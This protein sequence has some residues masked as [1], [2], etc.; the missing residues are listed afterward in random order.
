MLNYR[1][2]DLYQVNH[3]TVSIKIAK[4]MHEERIKNGYTLETLAEKMHCKRQTAAS[5]EKGWKQDKE[6]LNRIPHMDQIMELCDIYKCDPGYLLCFYDKRYSSFDVASGITGLTEESIIALNNCQKAIQD[7]SLEDTASQ[8]FLLSLINFILP[9]INELASSASLYS[10][11]A[12]LA[13]AFEGVKN[14]DIISETFKNSTVHLEFNPNLH[15]PGY[16]I[17]GNDPQLFEEIFNAYNDPDATK[18]ILPHYGILFILD[19]QMRKLVESSLV[20]DISNIVRDFF[21]NYHDSILHSNRERERVNV[22]YELPERVKMILAEIE[23][24]QNSAPKTNEHI[25][26]EIQTSDIMLDDNDISF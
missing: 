10:A 1:D 17:K 8:R 9:K 5:W 12:S 22:N 6:A 7:S 3:N 23:E 13:Y 4:R 18:Y 20:N 15:I 24:R 14:K 19:E 26:E 25:I 16:E 2:I 11:Y 21:V